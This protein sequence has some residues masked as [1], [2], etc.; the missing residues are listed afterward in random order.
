MDITDYSVD[1][2]EIWVEVN[3]D[4]QCYIPLHKFFEL[5]CEAEEGWR[6]DPDAK[7]VS[8]PFSMVETR[9]SIYTYE[10]FF[11]D[12]KQPVKR[13]L[14]CYILSNDVVLEDRNTGELTKTKH[15]PIG[16]RAKSKHLDYME[17]RSV[18]EE[19][20]ENVEQMVRIIDTWKNS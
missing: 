17:Q 2:T 13:M 12:P 1:S 4:Q 8:I 6:H 10:Q 18:Q 3:D 7:M 20:D 14:E 5:H 9:S 15:Y 11:N 16:S 19:A